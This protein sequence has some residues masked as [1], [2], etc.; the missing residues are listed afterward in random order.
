MNSKSKKKKKLW[1]EMHKGSERLMKEEI[2]E[3]PKFPSNAQNP[4]LRKLF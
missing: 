2:A 4:S 1:T 3:S